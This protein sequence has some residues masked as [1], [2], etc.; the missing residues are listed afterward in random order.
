[1]TASAGLSY[2]RALLLLRLRR[3]CSRC[4]KQ[5]AGL[6][7]FRLSDLHDCWD[8]LRKQGRLAAELIPLPVQTALKQLGLAEV[9]WFTHDLVLT[10]AG[11]V[12]FRK[13]KLA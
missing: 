1:M 11:L 3:I 6:F 7:G 4:K 9:D 8:A 5:G 2:Q 10:E 12:G 13:A